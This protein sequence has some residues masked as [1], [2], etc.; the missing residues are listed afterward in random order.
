MGATGWTQ[1]ERR[2]EG[3]A[4]IGKVSCGDRSEHRFAARRS[5]QP[6]TYHAGAGKT[7]ETGANETS[8]RYTR[9]M[10]DRTPAHKAPAMSVWLSTG[11]A[12]K[13]LGVSGKSVLRLIHERKLPARVTDGGQFRIDR[14]IVEGFAA[15]Q[16]YDPDAPSSTPTRRKEGRQPKS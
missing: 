12:G 1:R 13:L 11:E 6:L 5:E 16:V 3:T 2:P 15:G 9:L 8:G 10:V 7:G 14:A 4:R